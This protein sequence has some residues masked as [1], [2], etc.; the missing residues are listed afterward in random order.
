MKKI[1][2]IVSVMIVLL[3]LTGCLNSD[4]RPQALADGLTVAKTETGFDVYAAEPFEAI[5]IV[6]HETIGS[7]YRTI[8]VNPEILSLKKDT[9][10]GKI[11]SLVKTSGKINRNEK[12]FSIKEIEE[13][14]I[15]EITILREKPKERATSPLPN[16]VSI[17]DI[18]ISP[19]QPFDLLVYAKNI[20]QMTGT[21][22][23]IQFDSSAMIV[24]PAYLE[25]YLKKF[26]TFANS[27]TIKNKTTNRITISAAFQN[28]V[29]IEEELIFRIKMKALSQTGST[30]VTFTNTS[31][32]DPNGNLMALSFS[33]ASV[34]ISDTLTPEFLGDFNSDDVIGLPDFQ[35]FAEK[36]WSKTG[37]GIYDLLYDIGPAQDYFKGDWDGLYDIK[38]PDGKVNIIDFVV[39]TNNYGLEKPTSTD[40]P[41]SAPTTPNPINNAENISL[42]PSLQWQESVD[43]EGGTVSYDVYLDQNP[44]PSTLLGTVQVPHYAVSNLSNSTT[45]YWQV[46]AEDSLGNRTAGNIWRFTTVL[47]ADQPPTEPDNP[48]PSTDAENQETT[49]NLTWNPSTDPEGG[50]VYYDLY[51]GTQE[52]PPLSVSNLTTTQSQRTGLSND[53]KYYWKVVAKDEQSNS[54]SGQVWNFRTK[55]SEN[56][57]PSQPENPSPV[58]GSTNWDTS[59]TLSWDASTD[60]DSDPISYQVYL[61]KNTNPTTLK[62]TISSNSF[63][64]SSL[65][66][67]T[68]Y[69]WK[70]VATDDQ[71]GATESSIWNFTTKAAPSGT[72]QYKGL[73]LG[74][75]DYGGDGDLSATDDDADEIKI[76][77]ENLANA[78]TIQKQ[79]GHI[80]K[81]QIQNWISAFVSGSSSKDVFVFHY[82]GHGYYESGQ[83]RLYLSDDSNISMSE[84]RSSLDA[85]N[86]TKIVL[87]DACESGNFT[88]LSSGRQMSRQDRIEQMELFKQGVIESFEEQSGERGSYDSPYEYYVLTGSAINEYSNEDGF[89]NHGFFTFFFNDGM[90]NVGS[91]NPNGSFDYSYNA[92]GYG[93]G[94]VLD[95][96]VTFRELYNY[97]KDKVLNYIQS[98]YGETQTV[99]GNHTTADFVVG[100]YSTSQN[101]P[102]STPSSP[103]PSSGSVGVSTT[104][105]LSWSS[106]GAASYDVYFGTSSNPPKVSSNQS[107]NSYN[108]GS[109]SSSQKYYWKI[110]AKNAYGTTTGSVWN[111]TTQSSQPA[112]GDGRVVLKNQTPE[113]TGNMSFDY[114]DAYYDTVNQ[115]PPH[116]TVENSGSLFFTFDGKN[117]FYIH[118]FGI[119]EWNSNAE[120]DVYINGEY[121]GW[122]ELTE[123]WGSYYIPEEYFTTGENEVELWVYWG[124]I[125]IDEAWTGEGQVENNP[126]SVPSSPSPSN[127]AAITDQTPQLSWLSTDAD[128]YDVYFGTSSNPP[129]VSS[130]QANNT[131]S[132]SALSVGQTYYWKVTANNVYGSTP[133]SLWS[134]SV[135]SDSPQTGVD[136]ISP[137]S[138]SYL[139]I[140]NES[141]NGNATQYTG[142]L[143]SA[144]RKEWASRTV[145]IPKDLPLD[146]YRIDPVPD[147][148]L[149]LD[150]SKLVSRTE[151]TPRAVGETKQFTVYNFK[152][153]SDQSL[154]A[155]LQAEGQYCKLWVESVTDINT[156]KAQQVADEFDDVIYNLITTNF[157]TPS[158]VN[159]DGKIAILLFD[160]QDNFDTTG[161][162]VGGYFWSRD[163]F[164][165]AGSNLME[166]FYIDTY[167]TMH[168]PK[169]N[170]IDVSRAFSTLAHEFQHMVNFNRNYIV[171][172]SGEMSTWIDEGLSMAAERL[173]YGPSVVQS[174]VSY[175]N[176]SPG[177][178]DGHSLLYWDDYGETLANYALSYVFMQYFRI[179]MAQG[180]G[181]YREIIT[182]Y[183]NDYRCIQ[184]ALDN[185]ASSVAFGDFLTNW[186]IAMAINE[187]TGEYGFKGD[188]SFNTIQTPLYTGGNK[189]LRGGGAIVKTLST[190]FT[191]P[192]NSGVDIQYVG[193]P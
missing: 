111:F 159:G 33:P 126:P 138:G 145:N 114:Y 135:I 72:P 124:E 26:G 54:T 121:E 98:N 166:I 193:L 83:S 178:R 129:K 94:G 180:T 99:Q 11:L 61:D 163:L 39:F 183:A 6:F 92:D 14:D 90:G 176:S 104:Q 88:S 187:S 146:A 4:I 125:F 44:Q 171:E 24:D 172:G 143:A 119:Q 148:N 16:G 106:N 184:N 43:P 86:G 127:G 74:V 34:E 66:Y 67:S 151:E 136:F 120:I 160:I 147:R 169:S 17:L 81:S 71:G 30:N 89:L 9:S 181:I 22:F 5:E 179:Q 12:L 51:F 103:T 91:S 23:T 192:G 40:Q 156:S 102:P 49:L 77:F 186:R 55:A 27:L 62:D 185:Y 31:A 3:A 175:Y 47:Q 13:K 165:M 87:I 105:S 59:L 149:V 158:D 45:Y 191:D 131:Y 122:F 56:N 182:D 140:S 32:L 79:T 18:T 137:Y 133:G 75:T 112:T 123:S 96:Q 63:S 10:K 190:A 69:Y 15:K 65:S 93:I 113:V 164:N 152:T 110:V 25:D 1:K 2:I 35:L 21:E 150:R 36:Y 60:P 188:S 118:A 101:N 117:D 155:T 128:S 173:V 38:T 167:P 100:T 107:Y 28:P 168:Y 46:V 116:W 157:Y 7:D 52:N 189:N 48:T 177:V 37:D 57:P 161:G 153:D 29:D 130:K 115:T 19:N 70:I 50:T 58:S 108:P 139:L 78:Y 20:S 84:L 154:T 41:P 85:I 170:P 80:T 82:S 76:T 134:F 73:T 141:E 8:T 162:Y 174:R 132:P 142:T 95:G 109:L 64:I 144:Q 53:T 42:S 97:S 68:K